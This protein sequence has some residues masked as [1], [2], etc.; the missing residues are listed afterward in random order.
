MDYNF[1]MLSIIANT[2][3]SCSFST[4]LFVSWFYLLTDTATPL[5]LNF[6]W[7]RFTAMSYSIFCQTKM[8]PL[9]EPMFW[10]AYLMWHVT[11]NKKF[12]CFEQL[13]EKQ[14]SFLASRR[15][16]RSKDRLDFSNLSVHEQH[17]FLSNLKYQTL[18]DSIQGVA[19]IRVLLVSDSP[20]N[21]DW[22]FGRPF[23]QHT[24][25][26][27]V[28]VVNDPSSIRRYRWQS[29]YPRERATGI[30]KFYDELYN[31]LSYTIYTGKVVI[32]SM[33]NPLRLITPT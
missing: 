15:N 12:L 14:L 18:L 28:T 27:S 17:I 11:T 2:L 7:R 24:I 4:D 23:S 29:F 30:A 26:Y 9:F 8:T 5:V 19:P 20:R 31:Y 16:W 25:Y 1:Y 13:I 33:A 10:S 3:A 21:L 32:S 6:D 22:N